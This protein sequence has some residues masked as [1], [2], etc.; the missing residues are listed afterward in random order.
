MRG[1]PMQTS[2]KVDEHRIIP[3]RA[4]QTT[5]TC[6][7]TTRAPDHP[8]ACGANAAE[9]PLGDA[10]A[11]SSPRVRGKPLHLCQGLIDGRIIPARA[12]QTSFLLLSVLPRS[13]HPRACGA[14]PRTLN[15]PHT[16]S[17]SSPRVRGKLFLDQVVDLRG[18]II[19]ARAGQTNWR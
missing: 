15:V 5:S 9:T 8:R 6:A 2:D 4:G 16:P 13:D 14:N 12:G 19:P 10:D 18:R 17:G 1:K 11:G 7:A 3:A